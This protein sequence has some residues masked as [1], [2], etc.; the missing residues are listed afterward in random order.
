MKSAGSVRTIVQQIAQQRHYSKLNLTPSY[1]IAASSVIVLRI[2]EASVLSLSH[3]TE[4]PISWLLS[5]PIMHVLPLE[6][7][8]LCPVLGVSLLLFFFM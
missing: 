3:R 4:C 6:H 1:P 8:N 5:L 2:L 7:Q